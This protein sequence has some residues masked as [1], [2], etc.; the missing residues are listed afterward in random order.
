M[1]MFTAFFDASGNPKDHPFVIVSGYVAN[2]LQWQRFEADWAT[3]HDMFD[4]SPPFH[5]AEFVAACSTVTYKDQS[6]ARA[7]YVE[8]A[9]DATRANDF[10]K[11]ISQIQMSFVHMGV[12]CIV[13]MNV[14]Q[15]INSLL[16]LREVLPPYALGARM[17]IQR[18][19]RWEQDYAIRPPAEIIFEEG[20]FEQGKFTKL[21]VDEG[22]DLGGHRKSGHTWSLQN[23]P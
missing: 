6:N 4:V 2:Y 12:S 1:A 8:I 20:D 9:K 7:D 17:C 15:G 21:M 11:L 5:M 13:D 14:Y 10:L 19:R 23:R 3:A 18:V 22:E 16:E